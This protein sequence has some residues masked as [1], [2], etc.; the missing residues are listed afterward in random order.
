MRL[1][2]CSQAGLPV[3]MRHWESLACPSSFRTQSVPPVSPLLHEDPIP[4]TSQSPRETQAA[5]RLKTEFLV[6]LDGA[7]SGRRRLMRKDVYVKLRSGGEDRVLVLGATNRHALPFALAA[8]QLV[9]CFATC[10]RVSVFC[11][12]AR[13]TQNPKS[14]QKMWTSI[15]RAVEP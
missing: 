12:C 3:S 5:R 15:R 2:P 8:F 7:A 10:L 1:I 11:A 4:G 6:Q 9:D 13:H 14:M